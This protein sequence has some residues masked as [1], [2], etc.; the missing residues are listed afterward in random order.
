[1]GLNRPTPTPF[2]GSW[3]LAGGR[4]GLGSVFVVRV[5]FVGLLRTS[6]ASAPKPYKT[7]L[8]VVFTF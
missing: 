5:L 8:Q 2:F 6:G 3:A 7:R 1:M 4:G